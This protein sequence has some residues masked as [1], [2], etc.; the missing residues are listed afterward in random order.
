MTKM[1][2]IIKI[3]IFPCNTF[4][5][6][7]VGDINTVKM[8][9]RKLFEQLLHVPISAD[10]LRQICNNFICKHALSLLF[11]KEIV[12]GCNTGGF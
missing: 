5:L 7:I 4:Q 1:T 3:M 11:R 6:A 12:P 9:P 10:Y 2:N 8:S